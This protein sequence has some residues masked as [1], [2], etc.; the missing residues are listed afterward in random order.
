MDIPEVL[1]P[2][3]HPGATEAFERE[4]GLSRSLGTGQITMIAIGGAIGTGLFLGSGL[5][6]GYAGPGVLISYGIGAL[7]AYM[8][9][10]VLSEMAIAIPTAGSF[11]TYAQLYL[12]PW[13]G[14]V[15]RYTYWAVQVMAIGGE[16]TAAGLYMQFWL[17]NIPVWVWV[18]VFSAGL[19]LVNAL[20]VNVFGTFEYWFAMIKVV[21]IIAFIITGLIV[22]FGI[23]GVS[24]ASHNYVGH[25]GFFPH[26]LSGVWL[27]VLVAI[28]SFY[29]VEVVAVTGGEAERPEQS[30]PRA[31]RAMVVRLI[32]F[33]ILSLAIMLAIVPWT[34]T[35]AKVVTASPFVLALSAVHIPAAA[36]I[37]NFVI[38]TAALSSMNTNL[39][40]TTRMIYSLARSNEAPSFFGR[41]AANKVPNYALLISSAGLV[42]AILLNLLTAN[43]YATLFGIAIFGGI[44]VWIMIFVTFL[45]FRPQWQNAHLAFRAPWYPYLPIAGAV[46][47][48]AILLTMLFNPD[49]R[50]AWEAGVPFFIVLVAAYVLYDAVQKDKKREGKRHVRS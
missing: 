44:V 22:I 29:G 11:G 28:F 7:I 50:F 20:S 46:L 35:G 3:A 40:L 8:M 23:H 36:S 30:L 31:M 2:A 14:F 16:A 9:M 12:G 38:I 49:W 47:L 21:A 43:V 25:G 37:M 45:R 5:A 48:S 17:P 4:A 32:L 34:K 39:Y 13:A 41:L 26:G 18:V 6:V 27:A 33:Y 15:V 42:A 1:H 19:V 10:L 24:T